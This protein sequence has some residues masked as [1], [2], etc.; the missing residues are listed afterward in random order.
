MDSPIDQLKRPCI[1]SVILTCVCM[2]SMVKS[3]YLGT[4]DVISSWAF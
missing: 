4:S 2:N 1:E 3:G